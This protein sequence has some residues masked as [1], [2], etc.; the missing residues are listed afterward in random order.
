MHGIVL[1]LGGWVTSNIPGPLPSGIPSRG[2]G[3]DRSWQV[4]GTL[5]QLS[6]PITDR[7]S[8]GP[9]CLL[10]EIKTCRKRLTGRNTKSAEG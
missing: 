3:P 5:S 7:N 10:S 1:P 4:E 6:W 9:N 2:Q 8:A